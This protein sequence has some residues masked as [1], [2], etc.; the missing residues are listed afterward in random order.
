MQY[1]TLSSLGIVSSMEDLL[2]IFHVYFAHNPKN[3]LEF[4][5]LTG[6][7][8]TKGL[9]KNLNMKNHWISLLDLL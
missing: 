2:Q 6:M 9:K 5:K 7:I 1:G 8:E 4:I 3:H